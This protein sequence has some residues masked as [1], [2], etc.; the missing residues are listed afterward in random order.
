MAAPGATDAAA[1]M[2]QG[3]ERLRARE[4]R[5]A[6]EALALRNLGVHLMEH[7]RLDDLLALTAEVLGHDPAH[8]QALLLR[9]AALAGL[10]REDEAVAALGRMLA[11]WPDD[12]EAMSKSF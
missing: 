9:G 10:D 11:R 2:R 6:L 4:P 3:L 8:R 7:E 1:L 12:V 5:A